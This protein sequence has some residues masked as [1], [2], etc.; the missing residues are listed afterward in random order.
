MTRN[1][2]IRRRTAFVLWRPLLV[3]VPPVLIIGNFQPGNPPSLANR[4]SFPLTLASGTTDLWAVSAASCGLVDGTVYHCWFE[5]T[6]SSPFRD[7]RRLLCAD[8]LAHAVDWRLPA[9]R[10]PEPYSVD[11]QAPASVVKFSGGALVPCDPG[12]DILVA[13]Q[14][15]AATVAPT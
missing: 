1:I 8:P 13:A 12:G 7:G 15:I 9:G 14:P 6:D 11:D 2:L 5:V 10:L 3:D 4:Q